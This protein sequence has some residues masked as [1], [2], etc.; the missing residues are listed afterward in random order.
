MELAET[1]APLEKRLRQAL[2]E[3]L[4]K[5]EYLGLQIDE[6]EKAEIINAQEASALRDYHDKV[7]AL[8][9]VDDFD[10]EELA[11]NAIKTTDPEPSRKAAKRKAAPRTKV[12]A[13]KKKATKKSSKRKTK[14]G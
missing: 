10:P 3:G 14:A 1:N 13:N 5:S 8:L 12:A 6:A 7:S 11:R 2:K 4:I 9:A